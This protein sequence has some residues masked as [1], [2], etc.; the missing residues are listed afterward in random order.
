MRRRDCEMPETTASASPSGSCGVRQGFGIVKQ[1][2]IGLTLKATV[3]SLP[4]ELLQNPLIDE[5]GHEVVGGLVSRACQLLHVA[6]GDDWMLVE[7]IER[8]GRCPLRGQM[9]SGGAGGKGVGIKAR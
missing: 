3:A 5:A 6:H 8:D 2:N 7:V 4:R 1:I 9:S